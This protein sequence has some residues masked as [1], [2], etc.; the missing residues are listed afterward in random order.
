MVSKVTSLFKLLSLLLLLVIAPA[1]YTSE[2]TVLVY[3]DSISAAYGMDEGEGWVHLLS[4]RLGQERPRTTVV[5][6]SVS[7]ETTGGGLVRLQKTLEF[8]QPDVLILE[9]GGNDGL[10]GYPIHKIKENLASMTRMSLE[11][12]A[13]VLLVGMVLPPNYGKRYTDAFEGL[14]TDLSE[15]FDVP[16]LPF[17]LDGIATPQSLLQRDGIHPKPEAQALMLEQIWP[18]LVELL[19]QVDLKDGT[20]AVEQ[21]LPLPPVRHHETH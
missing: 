4:E 1:A 11:A 12:G 21:V 5:N 8:H 19:E 18:R 20:A 2:S 16:F 15:T 10:R 13:R 9:L 17:L 14:F 6:A 7:G 3:G